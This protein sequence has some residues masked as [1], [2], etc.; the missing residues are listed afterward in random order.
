MRVY[1]RIMTSECYCALLR[2]AARV[3]TER[4]DAALASAG[5]TV[6]QFSL[7]RKVEAARRISL[8]RLGFETGLERSTVGRNAKVLE[9]LGLIDVAAGEDDARETVVAL[10]PAGARTLSKAMPLWRKAQKEL[11][12]ELG[13]AAAHNLRALLRVVHEPQGV[14]T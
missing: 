6:A 11:E 10:S 8:T 13:V 14:R 4:Y 12:S 9:R 7:L 5:I 3:S 1:T 2:S